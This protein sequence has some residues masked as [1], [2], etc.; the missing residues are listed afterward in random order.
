[1]VSFYRKLVE[2]TSYRRKIREN[3]QKWFSYI[4]S[5]RQNLSMIRSLEQDCEKLEEFEREVQQHADFMQER[6]EM[7]FEM[8][9]MQQLLEN[10][11]HEIHLTSCGQQSSLYD[12]QNRKRGISLVR[13]RSIGFKLTSLLLI[14][15]V[16]F[17]LKILKL[18]W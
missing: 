17:V 18:G 8:Q 13:I 14:K 3:S 15:R 12:S 5:P 7:N 9:V 2:I 11:R 10:R 16:G 6:I 4:R 1:M